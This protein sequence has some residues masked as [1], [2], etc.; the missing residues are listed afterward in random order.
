MARQAAAGPRSVFR[1]RGLAWPL[2]EQ[3]LEDPGGCMGS[4]VLAAEGA[5]GGGE[6]FPQELL[7]ATQLALVPQQAAHGLG[8][9]Q[10]RGALLSAGATQSRQGGSQERFGLVK[11]ALGA[12]QF[13][14]GVG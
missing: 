14:K 3:G 4:G 1:G 11:L 6:G 7:G 13:A 5:F 8:A 12:T 2:C 10:S 9:A